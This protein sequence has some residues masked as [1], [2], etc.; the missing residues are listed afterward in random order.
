METKKG[1]SWCSKIRYLNLT[2]MVK[3]LLGCMSI[4]SETLLGNIINLLVHSDDSGNF[5]VDYY[6]INLL[7][8]F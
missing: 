5:S 6:C 2:K 4:N 3:I 1:F 8:T 7:P